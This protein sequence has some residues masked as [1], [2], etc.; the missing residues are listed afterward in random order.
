MIPV[1]RTRSISRTVVQA[2]DKKPLR[3]GIESLR[4]LNFLFVCVRIRSLPRAAGSWAR[5]SRSVHRAGKLAF[6]KQKPSRGSPKQKGYAHQKG[7]AAGQTPQRTVACELRLRQPGVRAAPTPHQ[8]QGQGGSHAPPTRHRRPHAPRLGRR[9]GTSAAGKK[10]ATRTTAARFINKRLPAAGPSTMV[11]L[12]FCGYTCTMLYWI[13][14]SPTKTTTRLGS[15][16]H[17]R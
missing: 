1:G 16:L 12:Y 2:L 4:S 13:I 15:G 8:D 14:H 9:R 7:Y 11:E 10:A 5:R 3:L 17:D 6:R